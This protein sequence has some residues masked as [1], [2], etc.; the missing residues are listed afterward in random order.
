MTESRIRVYLWW[1]PLF[2][3]TVC[4][5]TGAEPRPLEL[6]D[7]LQLE[8][9]SDPRIAPDGKRVAYV[10]NYMDAIDDRRRSDL[11]VVD[12]DGSQ[13]RPLTSAHRRVTSPRWSPDGSRVAYLSRG[14][15]EHSPVQ[16]H[17]LWLSTGTSA[18][19]TQLPS[20]P[21][22]LSWS[23]DGRWLAFTMH[24]ERPETPLVELPAPPQGGKWAPAAKVIR[25]V[26]YRADGRGYLRPGF[27]Q[28]FVLPAEGGTA[29]QLTDGPYDHR[30]EL[31]WT[32]DRRALVF[33]ANRTRDWMYQPGESELYEIEIASKAVRQLTDRRGPDRQPAVSPDGRWVAYVGYDDRQKSYHTSQLYLLDREQ[34]QTRAVTANLDRDVVSPTWDQQGGLYFQF[35]DRGTTQIARYHENGP[36]E[37]LR[38]DVGGVVI[39]RPYASGSF[40]VSD[41]GDLA[42]TRTTPWRPADVAF[43]ESGHPDSGPTEVSASQL[44]RLNADLLADKAL[45][46]VDSFETKSKLDGRSL[47]G[48]IVTPPGF[49]ATRKYPLV[50]EIHGG[51]YA[52]YGPRFSVEVQLYAAAGYVVVYLNPRGSTSYGQEFADLIQ[53]AYPGDDYEDLMSGVDAVLQRGIIDPEHLYVTGG[54]GGGVLT[55]WVVGKTDRFRAAVAAKP[56]INWYS[57]V[58]TADMSTLFAGRW[59]P[60]FPWEHAEHY[61]RRSPISLAGKVKT[62]TMLLTGEQ[63][64][65]TPMSESEQFFQALKLRKVDTVLVRIPGASHNIANRPSHLMSKV[66]HVLKWFEMHR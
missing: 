18:R 34:G 50:L 15:D 37:V 40:S 39:G 1:W 55:A 56:V 17:C 53:H 57:H 59:F 30:G 19:L 22:H 51:P 25:E 6:S 44:T 60:G 21:D 65:R 29:R 11:W 10:R 7:V 31:S 63:D 14:D 33:S 46:R 2:C 20:N 16:I 36:I 64:F 32:P 49:D 4:Q 12:A 35:D 45:G 9:A 62:P 61:H 5:L 54:S 26:L 24:V 42:F 3:A 66:A 58:L 8:Y 48:W 52:N 38:R 27:H 41:Q 43:L 28:L 23:P 13:H 47:A